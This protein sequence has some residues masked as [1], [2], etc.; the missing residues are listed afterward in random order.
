MAQICRRLDGIP[1]A[2]ELAASR[3][4]MMQVEEIAARLEQSFDV[5]TGGSRTALPRYQS[6]SASIQ[7]SYALL[8]EAEQVLFRRM[9]V[10]AGG[11]NLD[12][13]QFHCGINAAHG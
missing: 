1:L 8:S 4:R 13:A 2:I 10:F 3:V 7:W 12:A 11:W 5:L 9:A 6:L